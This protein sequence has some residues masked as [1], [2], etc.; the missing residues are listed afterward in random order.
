MME[1]SREVREYMIDAI[2]FCHNVLIVGD[3]IVSV[4]GRSLAGL[5]RQE[6]S[7]VIRSCDD[8]VNMEVIRGEGEMAT[9]RLAKSL[10]THSLHT[11]CR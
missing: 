6:A 9:S 4:N 5:T 11:T 2:L 8:V 10:I 1:G 3:I 7:S